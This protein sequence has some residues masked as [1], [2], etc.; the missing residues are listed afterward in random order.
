MADKLGTPIPSA[1]IHHIIYSL[2]YHHIII[3][4][5]SSSH[6]VGIK[7]MVIIGP[8]ITIIGLACLAV[9]TPSTPAA[10][11]GGILFLTG[12]ACSPVKYPSQNLPRPVKI[13]HRAQSNVI[14]ISQSNIVYR[15]QSNLTH[16]PTHL[17]DFS[18]DLV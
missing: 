14:S 12:N 11:I 2:S 4:F 7:M 3:S 10:Y 18:Q 1:L 15:A 9:M 13:S 8:I 17:Y 5:F 6:F 16:P